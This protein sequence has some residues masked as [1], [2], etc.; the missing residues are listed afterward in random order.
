MTNKTYDPA[1]AARKMK[2]ANIF[3]ET[4]E[5]IKNGGYTTPSGRQIKFDFTEM[6]RR[7]KCFHDELPAVMAPDV[8]DGTKV[9]VERN[10]CLVVAERLVKEGYKPA[11][12]NFASATHPCGGVEHGARAQ[13]ET[14]CRRSTLSRSLYSFDPYSFKYG[15]PLYAGDH[16]PITGDFG[17]IYSPDVTVFREGLDCLLM[18]NPYNVAVISC[19]ALNLSGK[20][21]IKL[22]PDGKMPKEAI[23]I[24]RNKIRTVFRIG[25]KY[26]ND[27]LVLGAFGCGAFRNPPAE[28][29]R[30][31]HEVMEEPEFK[32]K[33]RVITFAIIEDHNSNNSNF[34]AFEDEFRIASKQVRIAA[35]DNISELKPN[36]I[37][38]FGSNI[39]GIHGGGASRI[40]YE[41]FGAIWGQSAGLQGQSYAIPT[42]QGPTSSIQPYVDEFIDFAGKHPEFEFLVTPIG[43]GNAGFNDADIAPLFKGALCLDNVRLPQ[44]FLNLISPEPYHSTINLDKRVFVSYARKDKERVIPFVNELKATFG[45]DRFWIDMTGIETGADFM[46]RIDMAIVSSE[47]ILFMLSNNSLNSKYVKKEILRASN[48][49]KKILPI[50]LDASALRRWAGVFCSNLNCTDISDPDQVKLLKETLRREL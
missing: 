13:E 50:V 23:D 43:C 49:N 15:Y 31:F 48:L 30:L 45:E 8:P 41:K 33:Y 46:D 16:Y 11:L 21:P 47:I 18:E 2:N 14:I 9:M 29:A 44:S 22:R 19:A 1:I 32:N 20:Y 39:Q 26:S 4:T 42:M 27:A 10:D 34:R 17:A 5:Y 35:P 25:L 12:L 37:F 24:T 28:I 3:R 40:A 6:L 38:V 7:G 36:Q